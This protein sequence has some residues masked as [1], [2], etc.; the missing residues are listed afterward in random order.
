MNSGSRVQLY[1]NRKQPFLCPHVRLFC[2]CHVDLFRG[3]A[4]HRHI[5]FFLFVCAAAKKI[6]MHFCLILRCPTKRQT[7][8]TLEGGGRHAVTPAS[9]LLQQ[10][11]R[12][13][14]KNKNRNWGCSWLGSRCEQGYEFWE[15]VIAVS[16]AFPSSS[17]AFKLKG[18]LTFYEQ[19]WK[20]VT[21]TYWLSTLD[22]N[23]ITKARSYIDST[24]GP[25][26]S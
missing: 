18:S 7:V 4:L 14:N 8:R 15:W 17:T 9:T 12:C 26:M 20:L 24:A 6:H 25:E 10:K 19:L 1:L 23:Q 3:C 2:L 21:K 13:C 5:S 16:S 11:Q 22:L